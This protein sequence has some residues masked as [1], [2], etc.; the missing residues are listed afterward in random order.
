MHQPRTSLRAGLRLCAPALPALLFAIAA[1]T[2]SAAPAAM[3]TPSYELGARIGLGAGKRW[4]YI[5]FDAASQRLYLAHAD[6]V[7]VVDTQTRTRVGTIAGLHGT[8][9][10]AIAPGLGRGYISDG[11]GDAVVIFD[12][13]TLAVLRT[14]PVGRNP[15]AIV[16]D[17]TT[18]RIAVF[19]GASHDATI[20]DAAS[21]DVIA[22]SLPLGGKPEFARVDDAGHAYLNI[23]DTAE[24]VE[25][26]LRNAVVRGRYS[27]APCEEPTGLAISS[28]RRL[29]SVC[30]NHIAV[31]SDPAARKVLATAPIGEHPDGVVFDGGFAFSANGGDG[32]ISVLPV[33]PDFSG[34]A[35]TIASRRSARTID[36]DPR[37]HAL[38]LPSLAGAPPAKNSGDKHAAE[39][40]EIEI[41]V[42]T[43]R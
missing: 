2:A 39:S 30:S 4:D 24:V 43:R 26:D 6:K 11:K 16:F 21:G 27:L 18:G 34:S 25:V 19:N 5:T 17:P 41:L 29:I 20:L 33:A 12:V 38:Y 10:V 31:I 37:T 13:R 1:G 28:S 42:F 36:V 14:V 22:L 7:E 15:D 35:A 23:E 8:H 40:D 32:T 3:A 9:G